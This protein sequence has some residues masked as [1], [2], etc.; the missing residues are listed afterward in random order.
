V[1]WLQHCTFENLL[2]TIRDAGFEPYEEH[3]IIPDRREAWGGD[4][5]RPM[6]RFADELQ[7][8]WQDVYK[9]GFSMVVDESMIGWTGATNVHITVLPN[10]PTPAG[11]CSKTLC[12]ARTL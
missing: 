4:P 3:Q 12:D 8:H 7:S 5:L 9:P 1:G 10:K 2:Y 6:R 11:E